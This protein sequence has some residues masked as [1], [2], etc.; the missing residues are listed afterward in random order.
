[1]RPNNN[2]P[3]KITSLQV[4]RA[5]AA[6][7]VVLFH[8]TIYAQE[9]LKHA[10]IGGAF[11]F[12]HT[13]VDFF[14]VLSGFII[15][16]AHH[17]V[18][19]DRSQLRS[20]AFK[21]FIRIFPIYWIVTLT[22]LAV[23]LAVPAVAKSYERDP[24]VIVK[25]LL[26]IPQ[27]NLPI[28]GAAWT[29]SYELLFYFLFAVALWAGGKW[30]VRFMLAWCIAILG[31]FILKAGSFI[32][33]YSYLVDFFLNERN[34]EFL[35]GCAAAY[36]M[37]NQKIR[38]PAIWVLAGIA[39]WVLSG[40]FVNN[41]G[42]VPAYTLLFGIPSFLLIAGMSAIES[43]RKVKWPNLFVFLGDASY[44]IYLTHAVFVNIF[45]M[46]MQRMGVFALWA[47]LAL[48]VMAVFAV[49]GG[50]AVYY[51]IERPLLHSLR[52]A[53]SYV[54]PRAAVKT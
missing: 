48:A 8:I 46:V 44:S 29:L 52:K 2:K 22:K 28:I 53:G 37:L 49:A 15:F 9:K 17:D 3:L 43:V 5:L 45:S 16:Y 12:G 42:A 31:F 40:W 33:T 13:G 25:S 19:G 27:I 4:F 1:M 50:S 20:Y 39:G 34:L 32:T 23:L 51:F 21:R 41:N 10:F 18:F 38:L 54:A 35:L 24:A 36:L 11:S 30:A 47:N 14:F 7:V 6:I 26:L